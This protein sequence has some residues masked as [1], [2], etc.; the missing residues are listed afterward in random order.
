MASCDVN[1]HVA[2]RIKLNVIFQGDQL[3]VVNDF[4]EAGQ[5]VHSEIMKSFRGGE[6]IAH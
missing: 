5:G 2:K 1:R 3:I 6:F 4:Y